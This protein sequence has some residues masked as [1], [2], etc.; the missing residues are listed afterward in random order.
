MNNQD[1][2]DGEDIGPAPPYISGPAGEA[3]ARGLDAEI[4]RD[5]QRHAIEHVLSCNVTNLCSDCKRM[6]R[7]S[8][9]TDEGLVK[10]GG[11]IDLDTFKR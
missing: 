8:V 3:I 7:A 5:V 11:P 6:L 10:R 4:M 9:K 1:C 2:E